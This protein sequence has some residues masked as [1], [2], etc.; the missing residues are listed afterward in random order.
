[1][2][3]KSNIYL[4]ASVDEPRRK[5]GRTR[6]RELAFSN[7]KSFLLE[8]PSSNSS[9]N[10]YQP[11]TSTQSMLMNCRDSFAWWLDEKTQKSMYY[12]DV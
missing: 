3:K 6:E 9:A 2:K 4:N 7:Y 10:P 8:T 11:L 1:M 12:V 5:K